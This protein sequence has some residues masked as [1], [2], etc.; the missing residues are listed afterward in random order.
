MK[1]CSPRSGGVEKPLGK[2][3]ERLDRDALDDRGT[4]F[5]PPRELPAGTVELAV[6]G[7]DT[8]RPGC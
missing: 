2:A 5:F 8:H 1:S 4:G 6:T 7:Q 3:V